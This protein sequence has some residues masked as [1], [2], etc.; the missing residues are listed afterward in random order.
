M[1]TILFLCSTQ[2]S[3]WLLLALCARMLLDRTVYYP[4]MLTHLSILISGLL[5]YTDRTIYYHAELPRKIRR[6]RSID[7]IRRSAIKTWVFT[8]SGPRFESQ[9]ATSLY[10]WGLGVRFSSH[11]AHS[12]RWCLLIHLSQ[13]SKQG[14]A[15][16]N[17]EATRTEARNHHGLGWLKAILSS[18]AW[19]LRHS[20]GKCQTIWFHPARVPQGVQRK[21]QLPQRSS[22]KRTA[23]QL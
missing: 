13:S 4:Q 18:F 5:S 6:L 14:P 2:E 3:R 12:F 20:A 21:Q 7:G 9:S 17:R 22:E 19:T 16:F 11:V 15:E 1:Q 10:K 23:K 8:C